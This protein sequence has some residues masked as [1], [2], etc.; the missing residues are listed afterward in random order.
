[1]S[2]GHRG[3]TNL[4]VVVEVTADYLKDVLQRL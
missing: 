1:V 4:I 3:N 2:G